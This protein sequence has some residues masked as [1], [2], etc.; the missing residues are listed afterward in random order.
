MQPGARRRRRPGTPGAEL[1]GNDAQQVRARRREDGCAL[2]HACTQARECPQEDGR[3]HS[4]PDENEGGLGGRMWQR[5]NDAESPRAQDQ[6][7]AHQRVED[8]DDRARGRDRRHRGAGH[9]KPYEGDL[10]PFPC[11]PGGCMH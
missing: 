9:A 4:D 6:R 10:Q 5:G 11:T 7:G 1:R 2:A 3:G 8:Q